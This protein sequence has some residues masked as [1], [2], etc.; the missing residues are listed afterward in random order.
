MLNL[1]RN[2]NPIIR[3]YIDENDEHVQMVFLQLEIMK[4][5]CNINVHV[6]RI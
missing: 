1:I 5:L 3:P 2:L 4:I 6:V